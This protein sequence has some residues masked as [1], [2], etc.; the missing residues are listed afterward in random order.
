MQLNHFLYLWFLPL[1]KWRQTLLTRLS[2]N[3]NE[4]IVIYESV[5]RILKTLTDLEKYF[6]AEHKIVIG[7]ELTKKFEEFTR[8]SILEAKEYFEKNPGKLKWEFV[9]LF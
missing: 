5:H 7:R 2:E 4:T 9:I 6:W 3:K 8:W 1:K